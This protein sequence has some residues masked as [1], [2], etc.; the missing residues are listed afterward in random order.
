MANMVNRVGGST[1]TRNTKPGLERVDEV[2][3]GV[4]ASR[5]SID[6]AVL[7]AVGG[8]AAHVGAGR[9]V[10]EGGSTGVTIAGTDA[11]IASRT[12]EDLRVGDLRRDHGGG[13]ATRRTAGDGAAEAAEWAI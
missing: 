8:D 5:G 9:A 4:D 6:R 3:E 12:V 7:V 13:A 2:G 1:D 11:V 10:N